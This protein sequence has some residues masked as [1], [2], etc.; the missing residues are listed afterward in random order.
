MTRL[1]RVQLAIIVASLAELVMPLSAQQACP[2]VPLT[3]L[4]TSTVCNDWNC[5]MNTLSIANGDPAVFAVPV[6]MNDG[7]WLIVRQV[8]AGGYQ[9]DSPFQVESFDGVGE[10]SARFAALTSDFRPHIV[11]TPDGRL[12]VIS[13][14]QPE[15]PTASKRRA[16]G[17]H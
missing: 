14:R 12:L 17:G 8:A 16:V 2:C 9:D 13:L 5:V 3:H 11:S 10:A 7:R 6:A 15:T 4:W 1:R